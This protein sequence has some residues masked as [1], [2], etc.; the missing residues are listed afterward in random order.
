M[1]A[2]EE[3]IAVLRNVPVTDQR[4]FLAAAQGLIN[5]IEAEA[6]EPLLERIAALEARV[7]P[8]STRLAAR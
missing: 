6:R 8:L 4:V 7:M 3:L 2:R 5:D 1:T